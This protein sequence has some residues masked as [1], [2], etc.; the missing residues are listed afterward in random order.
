MFYRLV[1]GVI[2]FALRLFYILQVTRKGDDGTGPIL[3]VGN[4]PNSLL[5]P[6][7]VFAATDR[8]VTFLAKEPLFRTLGFGALLRGLGALPVY[9]K[10]DHPGQME[11]NEGTLVAAAGALI[12][13]KAITIFPE[14]KSHSDPQLSEIKTGCARIALRAA[15]GGAAVRIVPIGITY[16][17]KHRFRSRVQIEVGAP[18]P[19]VVPEGLAGDAEV[20]WV[21][22]LTDQVADGLKAVTL[23]L[24]QW[25]DLEL[26]ETGEQLYALR[27]GEAARDPE[28]LRRFAKGVELLRKEQ[29]DHFE[30]LRDEVM[31]FRRRLQMVNA[32][33][34]DL[35]MQ[36]RRPEVARFVARNVGG[37]LFGFPLFMVGC[38]LFAVPFLLV[39]YLARLLPLPRDRIATFKFISALILTPVW[40]TLLCW[41]A[42][43][44]FGPAG[45]AIALLGA[46]PLAFFT[47]YFLERR[48]AAIADVITF[49]VLGS[50][51]RLKA[52]LLVDGE[53]LTTEI[54][55]TVSALRPRV[56]GDSLPPPGV[57]SA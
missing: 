33:P 52:R 18:I 3:Y 17:Q 31:S 13:G 39:R 56:V 27:I 21:R 11:K 5:D 40:Q 51:S 36:Y 23:N 24:E 28:R 57:R 55:K 35:S 22:G 43:R 32:D 2:G 50:R 47:R 4:H 54:E 42:W 29:P 48:R 12:D 6:A 9:R 15:R 7:L 10:Q 41:L 49:F 26:I 38:A 34:K 16:A 1:R 19:V 8:Q 14:G 45:V 30:Y 53:A 20:E 44:A 37:L 25:E 46:L